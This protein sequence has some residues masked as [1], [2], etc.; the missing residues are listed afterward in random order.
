M[1]S[2]WEVSQLWAVTT[3]TTMTA[4]SETLGRTDTLDT[5][6]EILDPPRL[7][8]PTWLTFRLCLQGLLPAV[9]PQQRHQF[10]GGLRH[11]LSPGLHG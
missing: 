4:I 6:A 2:A 8:K 1:E 7:L 10:P 11:L 5:A 9:P 3:N